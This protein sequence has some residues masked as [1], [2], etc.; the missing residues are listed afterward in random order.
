M[1]VDFFMKSQIIFNVVVI[2]WM[3]IHIFVHKQEAEGS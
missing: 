1:T 3:V 2:A